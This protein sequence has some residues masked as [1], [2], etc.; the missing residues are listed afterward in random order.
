MMRMERDL[1]ERG[2]KRLKSETFD[3]ITHLYFDSNHVLAFL[4]SLFFPSS[5]LHL[6]L[7]FERKETG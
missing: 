4:P 6:L 3:G 2:K 7:G 1:L 5:S